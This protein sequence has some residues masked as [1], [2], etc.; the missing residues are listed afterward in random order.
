MVIV[1]G[2][3]DLWFEHLDFTDWDTSSLEI[4]VVLYW[5]ISWVEL[6]VWGTVV[7]FEA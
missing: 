2:N 4:V 7:L 1:V 5:E 6:I 3:S